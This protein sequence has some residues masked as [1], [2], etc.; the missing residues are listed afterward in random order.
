ME[1]I[2]WKQSR[3]MDVSVGGIVAIVH[4]NGSIY[5]AKWHFL[6]QILHFPISPP[7]SLLGQQS[8]SILLG[9]ESLMPCIQHFL[10]SDAMWLKR[11][12]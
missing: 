9:Q 12:A 11:N 1:L 8:T 4:R 6:S 3:V 5:T 2:E 10:I 7:I